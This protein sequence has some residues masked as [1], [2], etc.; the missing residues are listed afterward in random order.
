[1]ILFD[2]NVVSH[3]EQMS[4]QLSFLSTFEPNFNRH[5]SHVSLKNHNLSNEHTEPNPD[6]FRVPQTTYNLLS[7]LTNE[8]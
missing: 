5:N 4:E 8:S 2:T 1:M 7:M 6:D 3:S